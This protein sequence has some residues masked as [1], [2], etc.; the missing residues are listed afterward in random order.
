MIPQ[1]PLHR[2]LCD[3]LDDEYRARATY[4]AVIGA[5]GPVFPFAHIV[6]SEQRHIDVLLSLF[7]ERGL[8]VIEDPYAD[9][10]PVPSSIEEACRLAILTETENVALYDHLMAAAANDAEVLWVFRALRR[11]SAG[12]HLSAFQRR[13][14]GRHGA[15]CDGCRIRQG[16]DFRHGGQ[17]VSNPKRQKNREATLP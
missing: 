14:T 7:A 9:G 4:R 12:C 3:A 8:P 10:L 5:F 17:V 6:H 1:S 15:A 11:A 2:A 13:L 16:E